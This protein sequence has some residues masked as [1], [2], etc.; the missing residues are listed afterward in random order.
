[1]LAK[2]WLGTDLWIYAAGLSN[3]ADMCG[4]LLDFVGGVRV[5]RGWSW[6]TGGARFIVACMS[7]C[8][9]GMWVGGGR[10]KERRV[11]EVAAS[12]GA[13]DDKNIMRDTGWN[14]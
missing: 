13:C 10:L 3:W 8:G 11:L 9:L 12:K 4:T 7:G 2:S 6:V 1:V 14:P 5:D